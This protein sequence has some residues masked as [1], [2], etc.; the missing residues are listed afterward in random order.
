MGFFPPDHKFAT[1][2]A[3]NTN[4]SENNDKFYAPGKEL[5]DGDSHQ[6]IV[7]GGFDTG[8]VISGYKYFKYDG[9]PHPTRFSEGDPRLYKDP[10]G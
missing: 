4:T 1:E 10:I 3:S 2:S 7:C 6:I 8:H 5:D 9:Q